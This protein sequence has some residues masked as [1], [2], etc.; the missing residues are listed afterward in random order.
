M[1]KIRSSLKYYFSEMLVFVL[2]VLIRL[3]YIGYENF[4]TDVWRWKQRAY[5]FGTGIYTL[6]F[7]KTIQMYHP[8]VTL[9]W[10]GSTA[11][12]LFN[13]YQGVFLQ[14]VQSN[15]NLHLIFGLDI[16]QKLLITLALG[17]SC[18]LI[19]YPLRKL[20]GKRYAL[21]ALFLIN[22]E[23]FYL[24][25]SRVIH[26]EG[27]M[28][29]FMLASFVWVFYFTQ[30]TT[31]FKRLVFSAFF[32]ALAAL[33]KSSALFVV[34]MAGFVL[35][36]SSLSEQSSWI[37][38]LK[39]TLLNFVYWFSLFVLF[40]ILIWPGMWV[41]PDVALQTYF[42]G[43]FDVGVE[44][45]HIQLYF[46]QITRDPGIGFYPLA[47]LFRSSVY[48]VLGLLG[49]LYVQSKIMDSKIRDFVWCT[50]IFCLLY[51][52]EIS[53][54]SKK[55]DRYIIPTIIGMALISSFFYLWV[56]NKFLRSK[57][58]L[59]ALIFLPQIVMLTYVT[60]DYFSYYSPL[61]GGIREGIQVLEPKWMFGQ[62]EITA[63]FQKKI[64]RGEYQTF[65]STESL[66]NL[67]TK[68]L[69][70]KMTIAFQ[71][72]YYTQVWPLIRNMGAWAV[73]QDLTPE[74]EKTNFFVYP[75][76]DDKSNKEDRFKLVYDGAIYVYGVP[77]YH[78]YKRESP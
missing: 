31:K 33:T 38:S 18:A 25:L 66:Y 23:P 75:V 3:P 70:R 4:N 15:G 42:T 71:E 76:W 45:G 56:W 20:F 52:V 53:I 7:E 50:F 51:F 10:L 28:S 60:P 58:L 62:K 9:M 72:K 63:Y 43:V 40:F 35:F 30:D 13:F 49:Y 61:G 21:L 44:G 77:A 22:L 6:N 17:V 41:A 54:P 57:N 48:L 5:D 39:K 46:G 27:L 8:G 65:S 26:L 11:V 12:K 74:A 69:A 68:V 67:K 16:A 55:L 29:T 24:A 36:Y 34:P 78:V 47:L 37:S 59:F 73:L 1:K 14:G 2:Y 32:G 64:D 19:F